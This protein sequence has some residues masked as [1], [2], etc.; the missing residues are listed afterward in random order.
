MARSSFTGLKVQ[1]FVY[2]T[3]LPQTPHNVVNTAD[4]G[5]LRWKIEN[6]GFN[7]QK[8][9]GYKMEH[10]YSRTSYNALQNYYQMLQLAHLIN[11][12]TEKSMDI[13]ELLKQYS[14]QT[15]K[16]LW[17][18]MLT[19]MRSIPYTAAQLQEFISG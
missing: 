11:Q 7:T 9:S 12:F 3:D 5:R 17:K 4:G 8:N 2:I 10:K 15:I 6:E 14:K 16:A 18:E 13:I 1:Q 19:F